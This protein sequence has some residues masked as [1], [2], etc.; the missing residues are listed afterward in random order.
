MVRAR[1]G[2]VGRNDPCPCDSGKKYKRC[3]GDLTLRVPPVAKAPE[4]E[5][6]LQRA[7]AVETQRAAQQ[8]LGKP[9]I[10]AVLKDHRLVAVGN[11]I[12]FS[13]SWK[14]FPDFL[15]HFIK[16]ALGAEWGNSE[17]KK[18]EADMHPVALWYRKNSLLQAKHAGP[19]GE[20]FGTPVTGAVRSYLDLAYNLYLLEHNVELRS[21]LIERL[22]HRD[23][24]LGALT[25]IRVA[26]ML[27]RAGFSIEFENEDDSSHSHC[28]YVVT[29][30]ATGKRFSVEVKT[31]NWQQYPGDDAHGRRAV[32]IGTRRL[33][34]AALRKTASY[35]RI[36]FVELAMP[37]EA[38]REEPVPEPW[39]LQSAIDGLREEESA[40]A[41]RGEQT[42][43]GYVIVANHPHHHHL[44]STSARVGFISD[45]VGNTDFRGS[46]RGSIRDALRFRKKYADFLTLWR[47]IET[48]REIPT[49]FDG[50]SPHLAFGDHPPRLEIGNRY[51]VPTQNG[52]EVEAVLLDAVSLPSERL[53]YGIYRTSGGE[54]IICTN[55][56]TDAEARAYLDHPE[57]F[58]G[59][60]KDP[61]KQVDDP[62]DLFERLYE[63]YRHTTKEKLLEFM[64]DS[65]SVEQLRTMP[66]EE[67]ALIHCERLTYSVMRWT[68]G[69]DAA[70]RSSAPAPAAK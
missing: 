8:G 44:D 7:E 23:Q 70:V 43:P 15:S 31:R 33:L 63:T 5:L 20:I 22:K 26:G 45:G 12:Y 47:S 40:L 1:N 62:M 10:A 25:E 24:F 46:L 57:T 61:G 27:V 36:V 19:A 2:R 41:Q 37:D 35:E 53:I 58:F 39:W 52:T 67:L 32:Q 13:T 28:E 66:Q 29:R 48:H 49:T 60:V 64:A 42:P 30:R 9:I 16:K 56:M 65:P 11:T 3:H 21:R 51:L 4:L 14:T 38:S 59:V 54:Q 69:T 55:P 68:G 34:R 18:A 17:L 6:T 50:S